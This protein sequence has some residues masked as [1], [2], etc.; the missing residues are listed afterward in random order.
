MAITLSLLLAL[1][2]LCPQCKFAWSAQKTSLIPTR[3]CFVP[4]FSILP[5]C[6]AGDTQSISMEILPI[7][8]VNSQRKVGFARPAPRK[9]ESQQENEGEKS[10][11]RFSVCWRMTYIV[12]VACTCMKTEHVWA[13]SLNVQS[14]A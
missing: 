14:L 8:L 11:I 5:M 4:A 1:R 12:V 3:Q 9:L 10:F 7:T 13:S 2:A 6:R